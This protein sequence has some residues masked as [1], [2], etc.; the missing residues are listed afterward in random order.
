VT[1]GCDPAL[2]VT[3][4]V[5][6]VIAVAATGRLS[7]DQSTGRRPGPS[8]ASHTDADYLPL[9][10]NSIKLLCCCSPHWGRSR[11]QRS[12]ARQKLRPLCTTRV[13]TLARVDSSCIA[14]GRIPGHVPHATLRSRRPSRLRSKMSQGRNDPAAGQR[15]PRRHRRQDRALAAARRLVNKSS[16]RIHPAS[17]PRARHWQD[18]GLL[19]TIFRVCL[20]GPARTGL[21]RS[22]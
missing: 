4:T 15:L 8:P 19:L 9:L 22:T 12:L 16:Y 6:A 13:A 2:D 17:P 14:V 5:L 20:P 7:L 1:W 11:T 3:G 18:G 21:G 10:M